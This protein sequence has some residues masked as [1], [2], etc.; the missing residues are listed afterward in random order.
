MRR[1]RGRQDILVPQLA[2][3]Y[4]H[5]LVK[6]IGLGAGQDGY[7]M[8]VSES[9]ERV[10]DEPDLAASLYAHADGV[11]LCSPRMPDEVLA[12]VAVGCPR[13][14]CVNR[15]PPAGVLTGVAYNSFSA[16]FD[17][18]RLLGL[19]DG[20]VVLT[21]SD[22]VDRDT[23]ELVSLE[24]RELVAGTFL[25]HAPIVAASAVTGAGLD[26]VR[27]ELVA[28]A[29]RLPSRRASGVVRLPIDRVFSVKGFGT[30]VTGTLVGGRVAVDD[31]LVLLPSGRPVK[32]RGLQGHGAA[33]P[34]AE[35]AQRLADYVHE[36]GYTHVES[37]A[38]GFE[39]WRRTSYLD[40][41]ALDVTLDLD[42]VDGL[43]RGRGD[44][45]E[46]ARGNGHDSGHR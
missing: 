19:R 32:V 34:A 45:T 18:C 22:L 2:N 31:E 4:F 9:D 42:R 10:A 20:L 21:K 36:M 6:A 25:A 3:P 8:L 26:E 43:E 28:L 29:R 40:F 30:V 41:W 38:G 46:L 16:A 5:E 35:A 23:V 14:L 39:R 13:M 15:I 12:G 24:V 1:N 17:I 7:R 37:L 27:A 33:L 11:I 44:R